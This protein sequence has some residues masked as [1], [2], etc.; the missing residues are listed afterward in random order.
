MRRLPSLVL[1]LLVVAGLALGMGPLGVASV[2]TSTWPPGS[3]SA[4]TTASDERPPA[5]ELSRRKAKKEH[6]QKHRRAQKKHKHTKRNQTKRKHQRENQQRR[7]A[8]QAREIPTGML[9]GADVV[10]PPPGEPITAE[11]RYIIRL[12][13]GVG[14]AA[15][16]A[17]AIASG[18]D[19]VVPTHVYQY[20][21]SGFAAVIPPD[22]LDAVRADP[23]VAAVDPDAVVHLAAQTVPSG[24]YRIDADQNG[25]AKI[26]GIDGPDGSSERVDVDVAVID[27]AGDDAHPDLNIWGWAQ[28]LPAR[29]G[30]RDDDVGHGTHVGGIIGALDN[31]I[32]AVG[33][34]PGARLW[35]IKVV[36]DGGFG[37]IALRSWIICGLDVVTKYAT[38]QGDGFGDLEVAN[39]S[40]EGSGTDSNCATALNDLYHQ[41]Y[42]RAVAAGVTVV[43][44]AG[45]DAK[46]AATGVPA[47]YDEV[48]TVSALNDSDGQPGGTGPET[49]RG[50]DD[51]LADFSNFGADVDIAAPGVD[52]LSTVPTGFCELCWPSGY[53]F[54]SGT[55]MATPHVAGAAALYLATHSGASPA[56]VKA[57]LLAARETG[58]LAGDP[59]GIDEGVLQVGPGSGIGAVAAGPATRANLNVTAAQAAPNGS[60]NKQHRKWQGKSKASPLYH[61]SRPSR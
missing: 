1:H 34:A 47:T 26:D 28:C 61:H 12:R 11:N 43:V 33:V 31:N 29:T 51:T 3:A 52:I 6:R 27:S 57:A 50:P 59:D 54:L 23:R 17:T 9:P 30:L 16:S 21:F 37:G 24:I 38:D 13:D 41:A 20:A 60:D 4:A 8:H 5:P 22:K 45:N 14:D 36:I 7:R 49:T 58:H 56:Q 55:S 53:R 35:N 40:L 44:A 2:T 25:T 48:I 15:R 10:A 19:G 46:D 39:V 32:G 42:C 18:L